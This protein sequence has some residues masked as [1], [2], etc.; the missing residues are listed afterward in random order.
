[1]TD[2]ASELTYIVRI[3]TYGNPDR[4]AHKV[5]NRLSKICNLNFADVKIFGHGNEFTWSPDD[6]GG[7]GYQDVDNDLAQNVGSA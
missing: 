5:G 3:T 1:M 7:G 6:H 4:L 2:E